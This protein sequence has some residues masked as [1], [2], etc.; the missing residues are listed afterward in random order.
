M[1]LGLVGYPQVGKRTLFRLLT[2]NLPGEDGVKGEFQGFAKVRDE[3]FE[4][5]VEMYRPKLETPALM[6]F[7]LLP[8]L[9]L[10]SPRNAP[11]LKILESV[12]V[13]CHLVRMFRDDSVFHVAGTVDPRRDILRFNEELQLGDLL[14]VEKRLERAGKDRRK[15]DPRRAQ[16]EIGLL[17]RMKAHLESG[18]FLRSLP[19]DEDEQRLVATYPPLLTFKAMII[20]LNV[21]EEQINDPRLADELL[22]DFPAGEFQW[23]GVSAKIEQELSL[24]DA[25]E[26]RAFLEELGIEKPALDK[27]TLLCFRHLGLISFFT[28]G[29]DEVRAWTNRRGSSA[30]QAARVIHSDIER[31]FIRAEVI[32]YEDLVR[33]GSEQKVKEAGKL[34]QKGKDY[35]VEDGDI[36]NFLFNV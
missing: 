3:R 26:R 28:V 1:K 14:F 23:I 32:K 24:L 21:G 22:A 12:D 19:L 35:V 7:T 4:R 11:A 27:L 9:D 34:M 33:M 30:P 16:L 10:Q 31:G 13:I 25:Q 20:V 2:G 6:E 17:E 29:P 5:L 36:I 15:Q 8:D 18:G